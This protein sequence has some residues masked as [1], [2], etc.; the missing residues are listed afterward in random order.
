MILEKLRQQ[1]RV[2]LEELQE[3]TDSSVSTI[4]RDLNELEAK[5]LLRRIHGGAELP[6]DLMS[7][8]SMIEKSS[9]NVQEKNE[10]AQLA[11]K[12]IEEGDT[13]YLDAGTTT[14]A[15]IPLLKQSTLHLTI[16]TNSVTHASNLIAE[17][18]TV[19]I[20]GG[21]IKKTTDSVT[22]A[23]T[24]TQLSSY[25]FNSAFLGANAY[26]Q[27]IGAMTPDSEE[28]AVKA[29][30]IRQSDESFILIDSSKLSQTSFCR[31]AE[32]SE[33]QI[34]TENGWLSKPEHD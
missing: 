2:T 25:R 29:Q 12:N 8:L 13:I 23:R 15:M 10:I 34:L 19:Y 21:L 30:A 17:Q 11:M 33:A 9:K 4:R 1:R 16:V 18:L 20:L 14:G 24:L 7:E 28:A 5:K 3:I 27:N 32:P 6:Q 26:N 22:G 31:F